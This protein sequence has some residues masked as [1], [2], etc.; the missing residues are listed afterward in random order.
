MINNRQNGRRRGRGG[1]PRP[2]GPGNVDRGNRIDNRARGNASQLHEKYK[3]LARDAQMQGDRVMTEYYLQFADHY[4][5]IL[6]ENRARFDE[7][8]PRREEQQGRDDQQYRDFNDDFD[9]EPEALA[10]LATE[11]RRAPQ[12]QPAPVEAAP[13]EEPE[14][15]WG[16][17]NGNS[18][19]R[20]AD[21]FDEEQPRRGRGRPRR[22]RDEGSQPVAAA[23]AEERIE[24]DR[25]PPALAVTAS[26]DEPPKPKRRGRPP[27]AAS[28]EA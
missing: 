23:A 16:Q 26:D 17:G 1:G 3:T 7:Q 28:A 15:G 21:R 24:I 27:K 10:G 19:E 8:R 2:N 6:N 12:P 22:P 18:S 13:E 11:A 14:Q 9:N 5:R 20:G 25:L 4:F